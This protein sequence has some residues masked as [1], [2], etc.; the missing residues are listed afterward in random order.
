MKIVLTSPVPWKSP[1]EG[2]LVHTLI[3]ALFIVRTTWAFWRVVSHRWRLCKREAKRWKRSQ[4]HV[5]KYNLYK[6]Q[7]YWKLFSL[8]TSITA[9][10]RQDWINHNLKSWPFLLLYFCEKQK[11]VFYHCFFNF[12]VIFLCVL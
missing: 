3:T 12:P 11:S 4:E 2:V 5:S 1:G 7:E 10:G 6:M 9:H 8:C